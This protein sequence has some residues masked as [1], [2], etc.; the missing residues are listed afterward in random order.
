MPDVLHRRPQL[1]FVVLL[2]TALFASPARGQFVRPS[3]GRPPGGTPPP[4]SPTG[5]DEH[6][7]P[8]SPRASMTRFIDLCHRQQWS[9]AGHFLEVPRGSPRDTGALARELYEVVDRYIG[10]APD[11]LS[12]LATG[13]PDDGQPPRVDIVG[14]IPETDGSPGYVRIVRRDDLDGVRWM[15]TRDTVARVDV[16]YDQLDGR[17]AREHLPPWMLR[18]GPRD[19]LIWQWFSVLALAL[20][21][22]TL[23]R[24]LAWITLGVFARLFVRQGT[25]RRVALSRASMPVTALWALGIVYVGTS[26]LSLYRSAQD[27]IHQVIQAGFYGVV[28]AALWQTT[29]ALGQSLGTTPWARSHPG[30]V[31]L[32]PLV[33]RI[34]K[35]VVVVIAVI[36]V[37]SQLG[38]PVASLLAG[39]G[40]GGLALA[41]AA[42]KT[43]EHLFGSIAIGVD[44]PFRV[45]DFVKIDDL[46]GTV[47]AVGLRSTRIRTLDRT[48]VTL[49]NGKLADLHVETFAPRDRIRLYTILG[50]RH[51]TSVPQ[52]R[53]VIAGCRHVLDAHPDL[54]PEGVSVNLRAIRESSLDIEVTAWF[55]TTDW[56]A[57]TR[58]REDVLLG[59]LTVIEREG[60]A[61]AHPE[62][63]V[64]IVSDTR[65]TS[66][67]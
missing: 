1:L 63:T 67:A 56:N 16:W 27:F 26:W 29:E 46:T 13:D 60:T 25:L 33:T 47:E 14:R 59:F 5:D 48:V 45:G 24:A 17:W 43:G 35:V 44:Q 18:R 28:F 53:A 22:W 32:I 12:P 21:G 41:L 3:L 9:E 66:R 10:V 15:F 38:Y 64:S 57:Y 11:L 19:L 52:I 49:P 65:E 51:S 30:S 6:P 50:L 31:T 20:G 23:G 4:E 8:D 61:L 54:W 36:A 55:R 62:R 42:Q 7:S 34:A 37:F 2:L 58:I 39:L 40:I